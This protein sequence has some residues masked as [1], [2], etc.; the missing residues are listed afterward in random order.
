MPSKSSSYKKSQTQK[1]YNKTKKNVKRNN[2]HT[3]T[4]KIDKE[5]PRLLIYLLVNTTNNM[6][7]TDIKRGLVT[8]M[9]NKLYVFIP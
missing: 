6:K 4:I 9:K 7:L 8:A 2:S 5:D 1:N 3:Y